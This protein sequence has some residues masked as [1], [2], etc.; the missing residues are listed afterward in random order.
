MAWMLRRRGQADKSALRT[1][2]RRLRGRIIS[3]MSMIGPYR[4]RVDTAISCVIRFCVTYCHRNELASFLIVCECR[5][6]S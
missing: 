1:I 2:Y 5:N 6:E 4:R 3:F